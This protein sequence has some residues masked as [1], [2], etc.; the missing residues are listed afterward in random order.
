[1]IVYPGRTPAKVLY[2]Y[3]NTCNMKGCIIMNTQNTTATTETTYVINGQIVS[4]SAYRAWL[5]ERRGGS[6][7]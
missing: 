5:D 7:F 4:E 3:M 2:A 1:M 6:G